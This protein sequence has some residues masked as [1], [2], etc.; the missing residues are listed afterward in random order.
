MSFDA[1]GTFAFGTFEGEAAPPP[2]PIISVHRLFMRRSF[3]GR[4]YDPSMFTGIGI[5]PVPIAAVC[6]S[7]G[8]IYCPGAQA[9][10]I[11]RPGAQTKSIFVAG[12]QSG[13]AGCVNQ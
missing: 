5:P 7:D 10:N 2:V 8:A 1:F 6:V 11:Y 4:Q 13:I 12:I 3:L 9:G